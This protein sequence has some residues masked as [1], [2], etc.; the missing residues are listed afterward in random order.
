MCCCVLLGFTEGCTRHQQLHSV[1]RTKPSVLPATASQTNCHNSHL[2]LI[3]YNRPAILSPVNSVLLQKQA[4]AR[5]LWNLKFNSHVTSP[6][7][8][9]DESGPH[10]PNYAQ[11]P[12]T[13]CFLQVFQSKPCMNLPAPPFVTHSPHTSSSFIKPF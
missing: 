2:N 11:G 5:V 13:V 12:Q 7:P 3:P 8:R 6:Y 1:H 10:S 4:I 9:P